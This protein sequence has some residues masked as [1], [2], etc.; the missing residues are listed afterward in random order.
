MMVFEMDQDWL[1]S[2]LKIGQTKLPF[3]PAGSCPKKVK[4]R[5]SQRMEKT[6]IGK[7]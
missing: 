6:L 3:N 4:L 7:F 1:G 2:F 5:S